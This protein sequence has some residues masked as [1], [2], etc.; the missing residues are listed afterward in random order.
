MDQE[1]AMK[2][3]RFWENPTAMYQSLISDGDDDKKEIEEM[4]DCGCF[5]NTSTGICVNYNIVQMSCVHHI[6]FFT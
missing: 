3:P 1:I 5:D 6:V 4:M 2:T